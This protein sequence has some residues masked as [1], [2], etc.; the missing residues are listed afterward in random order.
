MTD[1]RPLLAL[2]RRGMNPAEAARVLILAASLDGPPPG[3][4]VRLA[5]WWRS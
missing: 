2:L 4:L 1:T 3:L 5:R